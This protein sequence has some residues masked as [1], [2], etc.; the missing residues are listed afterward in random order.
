MS[1]NNNSCGGCGSGGCSSSD[2]DSHQDCS[3]PSKNTKTFTI[4]FEDQS[5]V[6][7][8]QLAILEVNEQEYIVLEHPEQKVQLLYRYTCSDEEVLLEEIE[9]REFNLIAAAY[10]SIHKEEAS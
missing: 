10:K 7:C 2:G 9:G 8:K 5:K 4:E 6:E 3:C 1:E